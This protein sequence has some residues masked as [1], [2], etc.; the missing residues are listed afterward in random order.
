MQ[1]HFVLKLVTKGFKNTPPDLEL[2]RLGSD[3][4]GWWAPVNLLNLN[5][6]NKCLVSAGLGFDVSFDKEMLSQGFFLIGL[7]PLKESIEY[8]QS[9]LPN[10]CN[11]DLV[12]KGLWNSTGVKTFFPPRNTQHDSWSISNL[13][14]TERELTKSFPVVSISDLLLQFP[15]ITE[16]SHAYLKMD[17]EGAELEVLSEVA[18]IN[19]QFEVLAAEMDFLS[20]I[21]FC[22][23]K[24]RITMIVEARKLLGKLRECGYQLVFHEHFNFFWL[25]RK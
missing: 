21:P 16:S 8:A 6:G 12:P 13:Q 23:L 7:D 18:Q 10:E 1:N 22:D 5:L 17:I 9:I 19:F 14:H 15:K 20:L 4:G 24:Q 3:Y 11:F 25:P 2:V